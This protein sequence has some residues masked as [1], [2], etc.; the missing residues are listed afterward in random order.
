MFD[1]RL[2]PNTASLLVRA[3]R[4]AGRLNHPAVK[5]EHLLLALLD[6]AEVVDL[7]HRSGITRSDLVSAIH[8][9]IVAG[10]HPC[11]DDPP[12]MAAEIDEVLAA[13]FEEAAGFGHRRVHNGHLLLGLVKEPDGMGG[14]L[15]E[16][17][18]ATLDGMR[19][20]L[21]EF[22]AEVDDGGVGVA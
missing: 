14:R 21:L 16:G 13:T 1:L 9:R 7:L 20:E 6:D 15:L 22:F 19:H 18:G 12:S 3:R 10:S 11:L 5:T 2:S 17:L 4:E 8:A